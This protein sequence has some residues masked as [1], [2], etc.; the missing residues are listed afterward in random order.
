MRGILLEHHMYIDTCA[1]YASTP[2]PHLLENMKKQMH[3][4]VGHSNAR[5]CRIDT[6]GEMG[7]I[8]QMWLKEG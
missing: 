5:L 7:A 2:Y 4:L 1:S 8:M 3:G 6:T